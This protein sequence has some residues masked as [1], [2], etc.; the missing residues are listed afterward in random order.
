MTSPIAVDELLAGDTEHERVTRWRVEQFSAL[1]L[2]IGDA[3]LLAVSEVDLQ[4]AR[5]LVASGCSPA[6]A[7]QIL[8]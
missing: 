8:L 6:L 5:T 2:E 4:A 7:A 3:I 1:G